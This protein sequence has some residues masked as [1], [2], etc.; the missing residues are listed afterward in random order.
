M[1]QN[2]PQERKGEVQGQP[3][4][5]AVLKAMSYR[6]DW[7]ERLKEAPLPAPPGVFGPSLVPQRLSSLTRGR[8]P[9]GQSTGRRGPQILR[10]LRQGERG[11][12]VPQ[13]AAVPHGCHAVE[14]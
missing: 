2:T 14:M 4:A 11:C 10:S 1:V 12:F 13:P 3:F 9:L 5:G 7:T 8:P 6:L